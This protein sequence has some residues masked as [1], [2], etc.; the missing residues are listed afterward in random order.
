MMPMRWGREAWVFYRF[1]IGFGLRV[2]HLNA[3]RGGRAH[4]ERG[5]CH[6]QVDFMPEDH[7]QSLDASRVLAVIL[8]GGRGRA[9]FR[10]PVNGPSRRCP[11]REN[12]G[13]SISPF[14]IASTRVL[15]GCI[16]SRNS[17]PRRCTGIFRSRTNSTTSRVASWRFWR[18]NKPCR[19]L[20]GIKGQRMRSGS[21]WGIFSITGLITF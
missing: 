5:L 16:C 20:P 17:T 1:W 2:G 14:P 13:W 11:W 19:T 15:S 7:D 8:G 4:R 6:G 9:C 21:M 3:L 12:I 10:S 18:R